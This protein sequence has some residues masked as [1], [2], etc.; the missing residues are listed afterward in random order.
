MGMKW[1]RSKTIIALVGSIAF[2]LGI[3]HIVLGKDLFDEGQ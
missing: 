2:A 3:T 1:C